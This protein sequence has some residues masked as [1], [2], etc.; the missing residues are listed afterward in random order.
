MIKNNKKIVLIIIAF[1]GLITILIIGIKK[2]IQINQEMKLQKALREIYDRDTIDIFNSEIINGELIDM[3]I[4]PNN[5]WSKLP[6]SEHFKKKFDNRYG[7]LGNIGADKIELDP[8][9][10]GRFTFDEYSYILVTKGL[11][12]T[13]YIYH[14]EVKNRV[15]DDFWITQTYEITDENGNQLDM[16]SKIDEKT[17]GV[18][19][20]KLSR[21]GNDELSVGVSEKFRKKHPYFLHLFIHYSNLYF[22]HI[23]FVEEKSSWKKREAYFIVDSTLE[24][25]KREYLVKFNLNSIGYLDDVDVSLI[26]EKS[27]SAPE[28]HNISGRET[29][30]AIFYKNSNWDN[31]EIT[32]AFKKK[33]SSVTG[34]FPDID[35]IDLNINNIINEKYK[36][37]YEVLNDGWFIIGHLLKDGHLHYYLTRVTRD[38]RDYIDDI[39]YRRLDYIDMDS[40][41]AKEL[42]LN[43]LKEK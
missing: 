33:F 39:E 41:K 31:L 17:F 9:T 16:V 11:K 5:D 28:G 40:K 43:S 3:L 15:F 21:G 23:N 4:Q 38:D 36:N 26:K 20:R 2:V 1:I 34:T 13:A 12:Q 30:H 37:N 35:Q 42:Y 27:Y 19:F 7:V 8:Y 25:I 22:N 32:E 29:N 14:I 24:C 6:L 18:S 10:D